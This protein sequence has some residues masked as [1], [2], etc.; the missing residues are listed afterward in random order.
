MTALFADTGWWI[1]LQDPRD[2]LHRAAVAMAPEFAGRRVITSEMVLVEFLNH[3][4]SG[5]RLR[6][7]AVLTVADIRADIQVIPQ[8]GRLF[9]EG[10]AL[11]AGRLDKGW[12]LTD[13]ASM[14]I[15]TKR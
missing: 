2:A 9:D 7:E 8:S 4:A 6:R 10:L 15:M 1:A 14:A 12:S 13:C 3:F 5:P 11:Y